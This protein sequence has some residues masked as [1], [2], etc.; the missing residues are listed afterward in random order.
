[1]ITNIKIPYLKDF[2]YIS[3][4]NCLIALDFNSIII[5][6]KDYNIIKKVEYKEEE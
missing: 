2:I 5:Y 1:M 4:E 3:N 6:G